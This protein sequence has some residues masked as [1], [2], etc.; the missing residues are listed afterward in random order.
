MD[1]FI[2]PVMPRPVLAIL[3][4]SPVAVA[5]AEQA[6]PLGFHVTVAAPAGD[7][8]QTPSADDIVDG[9]ELRRRRARACL[10]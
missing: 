5:L 2:E 1:I 4:A 3:G 8:S 6:R 9:F 7:W 10:S